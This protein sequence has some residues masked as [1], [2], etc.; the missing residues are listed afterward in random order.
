MIASDDWS[1]VDLITKK[2]VTAPQLY[3]KFSVYEIFSPC[4][5]KLQP[6][7]KKRIDLKLKSKL[8]YE[9]SAISIWTHGEKQREKNISIHEKRIESDFEYPWFITITNQGKYSCTIDKHEGIA[10]MT[11][12]GNFSTKP[13]ATDP[14]IIIEDQAKT[15]NSSD[16]NWRK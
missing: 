11:L 9:N 1:C 3:S 5:F 2:F 15:G 14:N 16:K 13:K 7:E 6:G 12:N 10:L 8:L 4:T